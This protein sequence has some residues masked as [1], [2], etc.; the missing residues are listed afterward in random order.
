MF[1]IYTA[2]IAMLVT[3]GVLSFACSPAL[4]DVHIEGQVQAG[5]AP[6]TNSTVT[7][8]AASAGEPKQLAQTTTNGDGRFDLNSQETTGQD[9]S[10]YLIAKG[11]R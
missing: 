11:Q 10:L 3:L 5:G 2:Q 4:A 1:K 9:I 8:W 7:L 6:V